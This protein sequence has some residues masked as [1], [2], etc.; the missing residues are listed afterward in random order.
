MGKIRILDDETINKIAAGEVVERPV[1]IVKELVE[2]SIDALSSSITVEIKRG[3]SSYI[4][5]TD[6]GHGIEKADL[7]LAFLRH[8]T[9]KIIKA[10]DLKNIMTLGFRGEALASIAAVSRL[11]VLSKVRSDE[12]GSKLVIHGGEIRE[13]TP[14]AT[15]NGTTIIVRDLFFNIP[16]RKGFLK[17]ESSEAGAISDLVYKLAMSNSS[18]SF[19]YI[20][21]GKM[22]IKT[23]GRGD[24][25]ETVYSLLGK[26]FIESTFSIDES[27]GDIEL[28]GFISNTTLVRGNRSSQYLFVNGRTVKNME[29]SKAVESMYRERIPTGK[30]PS[31]VLFI[32]IDPKEIDVNIHP[33]KMEIRFKDEIK[34][35]KAIQKAVGERL[36]SENLIPEVKLTVKEKSD[37]PKERLEHQQIPIFG[38]ADSAKL[39]ASESTSVAEVTEVEKESY[40]GANA[41]KVEK[42]SRHKG[43]SPKEEVK[44]IDDRAVYRKGLDYSKQIFIHEPREHDKPK[45]EHAARDSKSAPA[46]PRLK[47]LGV[48]FKTYILCEDT[49]RDELLIVDQHAA[50]ERILYEKLK[51][52]YRGREVH[53]QELLIPEPIDLSLKDMEKL[54]ENEYMLRKL[55]FHFDEF[56]ENS[57][58][59]RGIPMIFGNPNSRELLMD[60]LDNLDDRTTLYELKLDKIMKLACTSA[61]KGGD[62]IKI[63]EANRLIED[64]EKCENPF[65]CPHGR[66]IIIR[67][68]KRELEKK[69]KRIQ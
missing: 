10:D 39:D 64:I 17:S 54:Q 60:I 42:P 40:R 66:P 24:I 2:N 63:P 25:K 21:D 61:I 26:E 52:E 59:L 23:P 34:I 50:H 14:L 43:T 16:V 45:I 57:I 27:R 7:K 15:S 3:G 62:S 68:T 1:S 48:L 5:V 65:T 67:M 33:N 29:I 46:F 12:S 51:E 28:R 8:S 44:L 11:E 4:R 49:E 41:A 13:H 35:L 53:S 18:I 38:Y 37:P 6:N 69:F 31:F 58:I 22:A 20:K 32:D 55:G 30:Y 19:T 56:G 9:S 36:K 47:P